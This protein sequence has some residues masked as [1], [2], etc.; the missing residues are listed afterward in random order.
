[1]VTSDWGA[2]IAFRGCRGENIDRTHPKGQGSSF[3]AGAF[4]S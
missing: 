3:G 1:M 4:S 2:G